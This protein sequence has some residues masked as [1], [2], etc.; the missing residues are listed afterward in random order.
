MTQKQFDFVKIMSSNLQQFN[1]CE[2]V[3][4]W[5]ACQMALETAYGTS[6]LVKTN[7][8]FFGMK[9]PAYRISL[10]CG[11]ING[12]ALYK[13]AYHSFFDYLLWL[14]SNGFRH[15]HLSNL[16][17]FLHLFAHTKY[18]PYMDSYISTINN[19]KVSYEKRN[20]NRK[21]A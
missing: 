21:E 5:V 7:C 13:C 11:S 1:F 20:Q 4:I 9:H 14:C 15:V 12:H 19:I 8:N 18:N 10:S 17:S 2:D 16:E 3:A 6:N